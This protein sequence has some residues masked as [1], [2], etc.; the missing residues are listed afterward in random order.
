MK[1]FLLLLIITG[2]IS[3]YAIGKN[4]DGTDFDSS[5]MTTACYKEYRGK[6]FKV[7]YKGKSITAL[8][9]DTGSFTSNGSGRVLDLSLKAFSLLAKPS[10][11]ILRGAK[12]E[13]L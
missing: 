9:N 10:I 8:C 11:G 5:R 1:Q 12:I 3:W 7:T 4:R 6:T 13:I 2:S